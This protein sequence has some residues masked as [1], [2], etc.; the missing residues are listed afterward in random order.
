MIAWLSPGFSGFEGVDRR[1]LNAKA[2]DALSHDN[3]FHSVLGL[4]DVQTRAYK[5]ERDFFEGCRG[6][7]GS[8]FALNARAR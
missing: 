5:P 8:A 1:C 2:G 6:N 3:L 4:L 7:A